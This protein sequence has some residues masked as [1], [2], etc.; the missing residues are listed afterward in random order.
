MTTIRT[1]TADPEEVTALS[2]R[3]RRAEQRERLQRLVSTVLRNVQDG[4][5]TEFNISAVKK[6]TGLD[7]SNKKDAEQLRLKYGPLPM[8]GLTKASVDSFMQAYEAMTIENPI[9]R[10]ARVWQVGPGE[11]DLVSTEMTKWDGNIMLNLIASVTK[12]QGHASKVMQEII[13]LA[14]AHGATIEMEVVPVGNNKKA[15]PSTKQLTAWYK[16]FGFV[17]HEFSSED[18][19]ML[20]REPK[21]K[22][23]AQADAEPGKDVIC[24]LDGTLCSIEWRRHFVTDGQDDWKSFFAG[25]PF[26]PVNPEVLAKL[27]QFEREGFQINYVSARPDQYRKQTAAWLD[28]HGCPK[29]QLI[30][31]SQRDM[32]PDEQVKQDILDENF[33]VDNVH[34]VLD[35]R[36]QVIK[37]WKSNGIEVI[38]ITDPGLQP[39]ILNQSKAV[40]SALAD[41]LSSTAEHAEAASDLE[42]FLER[43]IEFALGTAMDDAGTPLDKH[44]DADGIDPATKKRMLRDCSQF[45]N[46]AK[47]LL[48]QSGMDMS[49]AAYNFLMS[50]N[51]AGTGFWDVDD[52]KNQ[53]A[54]SLGKKLHAIAKSFGEFDLYVGDDGFL[55]GG[56]DYVPEK[57]N[58]ASVT[59]ATDMVDPEQHLDVK[60]GTSSDQLRRALETIKTEFSAPDG[61]ILSDAEI[62]TANQILNELENLIKAVETKMAAYSV[63]NEEPKRSED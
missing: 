28:K 21:G 34:V 15:I 10:N 29:G 32:R 43:Y 46:K 17:E 49:D 36:P 42:S 5:A 54:V 8:P 48:E 14:D 24:D 13:K 18:E 2:V 20:V 57:Y 22:K 52:Y 33:D 41:M 35:D 16:K 3:Q 56:S 37:M 39:A 51:A 19:M 9:A 50:R 25:I 59:T 61:Q 60:V 62:E 1:I 58:E 11:R 6:L 38:E 55:H 40:Q 27:K 31:R 30:M 45:I 26:D 44:F 7:P 53:E 63:E 12:N 47:T 23:P 4:V